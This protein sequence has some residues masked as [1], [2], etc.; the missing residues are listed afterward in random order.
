MI[1]SKFCGYCG[2]PI[3]DGEKFCAKC[4]CS[5]EDQMYERNNTS[6]E[7]T[8]YIA[9]E[10]NTDNPTKKQNKKSKVI[11]AIC[12]VV[13]IL[14]TCVSV[15]L[16]IHIDNLHEDTM[17]S[18][19]DYIDA[20][21]H[22]TEKQMV[23]FYFDDYNNDGASEAFAIVGDK[24]EKDGYFGEA[25][26]W[27]VSNERTETVVENITG[28][29]NGML[30]TG[31]Q[32]FVSIEKEDENK[33]SSVSYIFGVKNDEPY[34][35]EISGEYMNVRQDGNAIIGE[36]I[37]TK[38]EIT[39]VIDHSGEFWPEKV[40]ETKKTEIS[41]TTTTASENPDKKILE[42]YKAVL[43]DIRKNPNN[44]Y[45]SAHGEVSSNLFAI[46]DILGDESKELIILYNDTAGLSAMK[47]DIWSF[48]KNNNTAKKIT[49]TG[50]FINFYKTGYCTSDSYRN[51]LPGTKI[52]PYSIGKIDINN[53]L[54]PLFYL[55]C[56]E[57][58]L[59]E[60]MYGAEITFP[61][62]DDK[63]NDGIVYFRRDSNSDDEIAM[64]EQEYEDFV[65]QY[66][67]ENQKINLDY[68]ELTESNIN[69]IK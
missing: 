11:I 52:H 23:E 20:L 57:K 43:R 26:V 44:Y 5:T 53:G 29:T 47:A 39:F 17:Q 25:D 51:S 12:L 55:H 33:K 18:Q 65:N 30:D 62:G 21:K 58:E 32:K 3:L 36:S 15:G 63:D 68:K 9:E 2:A 69:A 56:L 31:E 50:A 60:E 45:N 16:I 10:S 66:V 6:N 37:E 40:S 1:M 7:V 42:S 38:D 35:P 49:E 4:G 67:P 61:A 19:Q 34:E 22:Y 13:A 41:V 27:Y 28:H 46:A 24:T 64:T 54:T 14:A 8:T 59:C 48:D